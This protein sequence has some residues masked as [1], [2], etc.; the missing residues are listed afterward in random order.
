MK[1]IKICRLSASSSQPVDKNMFTAP[2][3][4]IK[5]PRARACLSALRLQDQE[6]GWMDSC[7]AAGTHNA[8][9]TF[10]RKSKKGNQKTKTKHTRT[11]AHKSS[12]RSAEQ[13]RCYCYSS[14][15]CSSCPKIQ[16]TVI[17]IC[18]ERFFYHYKCLYISHPSLL[19]KTSLWSV[20]S[21]S[22]LC[23][24]RTSSSIAKGL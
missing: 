16:L 4:G 15:S 21:H 5:T 10:C 24:Q 23:G 22:R 6:R 19:Q 7:G 3:R 2:G 1:A 12:S 17:H 11:H 13:Q 8:Q 9:K 14:I 20:F 18:N